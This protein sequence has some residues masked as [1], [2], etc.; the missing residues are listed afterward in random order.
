MDLRGKGRKLSGTE[1]ADGCEGKRQAAV[2]RE[3]DG[4]EGGKETEGKLPVIH[5]GSLGVSTFKLDLLR[6]T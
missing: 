4:C 1:G 2:T 3:A 6:F 5:V